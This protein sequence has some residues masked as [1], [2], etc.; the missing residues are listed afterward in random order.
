MNPMHRVPAALAVLAV[1]LI[2]CGQQAGGQTAD[3]AQATTSGAGAPSTE[4]AP[5]SASPRP[6]GT[7]SG[8]VAVVVPGEFTVCIPINNVLRQGTEEQVVVPHPEGDMTIERMRGYTWSGTHTATDPRFSGTHYYSW[9]ADT[10][11]LAS[12]DEGP[13]AYAEGLRIENA[14]GAWQGEASGVTLPDGTSANGPVLLAGEGAYE[15]L[16]AVL[17]ATEAGCFIDFRGIVIEVPDPPVPAT[18]E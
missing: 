10:Y 9:D 8:D 7:G 13:L 15:G 17:L 12:G 6:S 14:E 5:A 1:S 4:P 11:T 18:T 3:A 2:G 16:T